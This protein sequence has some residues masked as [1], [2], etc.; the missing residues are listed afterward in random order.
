[1]KWA[2]A[3][4]ALA[5]GIVLAQPAHVS[6]QENVCMEDEYLA[7]WWQAYNAWDA[8]QCDPLDWPTYDYM[9]AKYG[10]GR[11]WMPVEQIPWNPDVYVTHFVGISS[12]GAW[13]FHEGPWVQMTSAAGCVQLS[14]PYWQGP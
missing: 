5:A 6:A 1:M 14:N 4:I 10:I 12:N 2:I 9:N 11:W 13:S 7:G 8:T 3:A